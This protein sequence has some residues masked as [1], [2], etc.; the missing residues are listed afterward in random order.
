M[1]TPPW[2]PD[3]ARLR[4]IAAADRPLAPHECAERARQ[5]AALIEPGRLDRSGPGQA[6]LLWHDEHSEAGLNLWWQPATPVTT[7][8]PARVPPCT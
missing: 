2:E 6:V 5:A 1:G 3:R 7:T 4:A 8:T